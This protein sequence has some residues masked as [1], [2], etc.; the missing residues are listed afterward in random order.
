MGCPQGPD[1]VQLMVTVMVVVFYHAKHYKNGDGDGDSD[2]VGDSDG[3]GV[4][5]R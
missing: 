4:L 5:S 3:D 2:S 1:K